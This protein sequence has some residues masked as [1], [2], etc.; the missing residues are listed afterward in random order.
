MLEYWKPPTREEAKAIVCSENGAGLLDLKKLKF[1][2]IRN[3]KPINDCV[4]ADIDG[5]G[6]QEVILAKQDGYLLIYDETGKLIKS[7]LIGEQVRSIAA[8]PSG[9]GRQIVVAAL[10]KRLVSFSLDL[11]EWITIAPGEYQR[12]AVTGKDGLLLAFG[13]EAVID[14]LRLLP[15]SV[16]IRE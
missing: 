13:D 14:A 5:D 15:A 12:L 4:I 9:D 6:S 10:P 16:R 7:V 11:A 1:D 8:V 3:V 2:W